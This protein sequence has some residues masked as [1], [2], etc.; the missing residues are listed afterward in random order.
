VA[1]PAPPSILVTDDEPDIRNLVLQ[2]LRLPS[3]KMG[4]LRVLTASCAEEALAIM[5]S[6]AV[7]V[8]LS[9]YRMPGKNGA[10]LL[11]EVRKRWPSVRRILMT[12]YDEGFVG[13]A[14]RELAA[15]AILPKPWEM[16]QL[17]STLRTQ[18][19]KGPAGSG[20]LT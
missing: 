7:D 19:R 9:D 10:Q 20:P 11:A 17:L 3:T 4:P 18:I 5:E 15:D 14:E 8:I 6:D 12:G 2:V 16:E 1:A 13:E